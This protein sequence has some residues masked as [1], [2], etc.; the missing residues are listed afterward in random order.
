MEFSEYQIASSKTDQMPVGRDG[1][2]T[3]IMIPLL[4]L[5]GE[6]GSLLTEYK[7]F[8]RDKAAYKVFKQRVAEELGDILW[9]VANIA[10]KEGL[11]L[12]EIAQ[13]NLSKT[14]DRWHSADE[15]LWGPRLFDDGYPLAQQF[16][17]TFEI[18]LVTSKADDGK[19]YVDLFYQNRSFGDPLRDNAPTDDGYRF[20]DM[21]HL[22]YL[23]VLGWAPVLRGEKFF[24]CKRKDK[25]EVDEIEDG[26]RA[27]VIDEAISALVFVAAKDYS[28]FEGAN[29]VD[30]GILRTIKD[31]T[32]HLEVSRCSARQWETAI[33][34][35]FEIWRQVK[36]HKT[37]SLVGDL[38]NRSLTFVPTLS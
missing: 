19:E 4:G 34:R 21:F 30:Y 22:S 8:L 1:D 35:G 6:A 23:T 5:A 37:G 27:A 38:L 24:N 26:G 3:G 17:R 28:F 13:A 36:Q 2:I 31:L 20:H 18:S 10:A 25:R 12:G 16:P 33:L 9:Y 32:S 14:F 7:K 11:D 15:G 29:T